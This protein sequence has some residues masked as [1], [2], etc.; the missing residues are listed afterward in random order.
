[1][2]GG[3]KAIAEGSN[4]L[5]IEESSC[6]HDGLRI[7]REDTS[8]RTLMCYEEACCGPNA[9]PRQDSSSIV[10]T[11]RISWWLRTLV[12]IKVNVEAGLTNRLEAEAYS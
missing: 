7:V 8:L 2:C 4:P 11:P 1:M 6:P 3:H 12:G 10:H 5:S 9:F